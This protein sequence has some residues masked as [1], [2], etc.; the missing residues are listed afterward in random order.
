VSDFE[1]ALREELERIALSFVGS[2]G[3]WQR[4]LRDARVD[5]RGRRP[6]VAR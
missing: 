6:S 1:A 2:A 5:V 4:I 3:D